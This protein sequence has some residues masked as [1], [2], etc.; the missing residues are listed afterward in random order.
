MCKKELFLCW[1]EKAQFVYTSLIII[2]IS[3][4]ISYR[5]NMK[6]KI[7]L[8]HK[9]WTISLNPPCTDT[10]CVFVCNV[11]MIF[12]MC[13][14]YLKQEVEMLTYKSSSMDNRE[15]GGSKGDV[16]VVVEFSS[17]CGKGGG[18]PKFLI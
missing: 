15:G 5:E 6:E 1:N 7:T 13:L 14:C 8:L 12:R 3:F 18:S 4:L 11:C 16:V 2:L 17:G 9:S 10:L